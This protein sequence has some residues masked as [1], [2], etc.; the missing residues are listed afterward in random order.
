MTVPLQTKSPITIE[1]VARYVIERITTDSPIERKLRDET[2]KLPNAQ[3]ISGSDVGSLLTILAQSVQTKKAIEIGTFTGYTALKIAL[4]LPSSGKLVCC[5]INADWT[6][7]GLPFWKEAGVADKIDLRIA[8][9]QETLKQLSANGEDG[10]Y[11]FAF[12]D[13]DKNGYDAYYEAC[14]NL[15]RPG[16]LILLDNMLQ[17]GRVADSTQ[18]D[19]ITNSIRKLNDKIAADS[20]VSSCLMT[21]GDGVMLARKNP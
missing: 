7:I 13:A 21:I 15:I 12:I 20:R 19:G 4:A 5:D 6:N 18:Q 9:A 8:P 2:M 14:L 16:G 3:M 10:T 17:R 1:P 11:D